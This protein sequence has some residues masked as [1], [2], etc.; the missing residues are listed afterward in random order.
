MHLSLAYWLLIG[1]LAAILLEAI[2]GAR[3]VIRAHYE[4]K[5]TLASLSM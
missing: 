5:D 2:L 3:G 4:W 1:R